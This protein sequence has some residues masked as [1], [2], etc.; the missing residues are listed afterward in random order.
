MVGAELHPGVG[1]VVRVEVSLPVAA[2]HTVDGTTGTWKKET[3]DRKAA[4]ILVA[5]AKQGR[6]VRVIDEDATPQGETGNPAQ[7]LDEDTKKLRAMSDP[8]LDSH[9]E[10]LQLHAQAARQARRSASSAPGPR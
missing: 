9:R 10:N 4:D 5:F 6:N 8:D 2:G 7:Q 1:T 3:R